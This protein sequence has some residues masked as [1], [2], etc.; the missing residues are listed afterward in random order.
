MLAVAGIAGVIFELA[1]SRLRKKRS[2][3]PAL[4]GGYADPAVVFGLSD[5]LGRAE[6][7]SSP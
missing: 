3:R 6:S 2:S 4:P 7:R 1:T 5:G